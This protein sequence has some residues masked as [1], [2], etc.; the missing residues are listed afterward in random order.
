MRQWLNNW[1]R[2]L[3]D[4]LRHAESK[5]DDHIW[6]LIEH[7]L[8]NSGKKPIPAA[9]R[10][11]AAIA[12]IS[13]LLVAAGGLFLLN[14]PGADPAYTINDL[15][16]GDD[17]SGWVLTDTDRS[18]AA[19]Q[20][21]LRGGVSQRIVNSDGAAAAAAEGSDA[22]ASLTTDIDPQQT[23]LRREDEV[24]L[25]TEEITEERTAAE[26]AVLEMERRPR[27]VDLPSSG[28]DLDYEQNIFGTPDR[29]RQR[30]LLERIASHT[31]MEGGLLVLA[32]E[33]DIIVRQQVNQLAVQPV[34]VLL[35]SGLD[36]G[37]AV[38][39]AAGMTEELTAG[40]LGEE[41]GDAELDQVFQETVDITSAAAVELAQV[42][43][44]AFAAEELVE[45]TAE[46]EVSETAWMETALAE[47]ESWKAE[48]DKAIEE[49]DELDQ[50]IEKA[51][52]DEEDPL[53]KQQNA[54]KDL[55]RAH[56][57]N[58][59]FH[60]GTV[61]G[62]TTTWVTRA[63]R[64]PE[65]DRSYVDYRFNAGYQVGLNMGYDI[66][67][68]F[69]L[70]MEFKYSD[71]G[72]RYFHP[73]RNKEQQI[74]LRYVELPVYA[75]MKHSKLSAKMRPLVFNYIV[76]VTFSD[77]RTINVS[78]GG[79]DQ[80]FGQDYNTSL[81]GLSGGF[82]F[83]FYINKNFFWTFGSRVGV[84]GDAKAFPR[85]NDADG[86]PLNISAGLFTRFNFRLPGK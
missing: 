71:E 46:T 26:L 86:G 19:E 10:R 57:I 84:S 41:Y 18:T 59:G 45:A 67:E 30:E 23:S 76:G 3:A 8:D 56:N 9:F 24:L 44:T 80:R 58:K 28:L 5:P 54:T 16:K 39:D 15:F 29:L 61:T 72:G 20:S 4:R 38:V 75:K 65:V 63:S 12:V 52:I 73:L 82:D 85:F 60:I 1:E 36:E 11:S 47:L 64:N 68:H 31:G 49:D 22:S 33:R 50:L 43:E 42:L 74:D 62:F 17:P 55:Y 7:E 6:D 79:R 37:L 77:L 40:I 81:W 48:V 78:N 70:M 51:E 14:T 25:P 32:E 53:T 35:E 34:V 27:A 69:G 83:D 66:T 21:P 13:L 2:R